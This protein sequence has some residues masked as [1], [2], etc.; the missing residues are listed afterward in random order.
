MLTGCKAKE[1]GERGIAGNTVAPGAVETAFG[2]G[3][4]RGN[5]EVRGAV[6]RHDRPRP[7][8]LLSG[9][10]RWVNAQRTEVSGGQGI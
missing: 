7:H 9:D 3:G 4:V 5:P 2:G 8:R 10:N 6:R 1:M